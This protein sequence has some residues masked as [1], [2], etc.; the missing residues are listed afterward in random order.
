MAYCEKNT[1]ASRVK[2]AKAPHPTSLAKSNVPQASS[3]VAK[4]GDDN[5]DLE[6]AR[7]M[8]KSF[9]IEQFRRY[10]VGK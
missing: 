2:G 10:S 3:F 4:F 6:S 5:P 8:T 7:T 1:L 9:V